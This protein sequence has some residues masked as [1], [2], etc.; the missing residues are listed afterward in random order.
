MTR[1]KPANNVTG[2]DGSNPL[3]IPDKAA[4]SFLGLYGSGSER[5]LGYT[6]IDVEKLVES[7]G[8]ELLFGTTMEEMKEKLLTLQKRR[9]LKAFLSLDENAGWLRKA[10]DL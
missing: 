8:A 5:K 3:G 9:H 7:V 4:E 10:K 6:K 1:A 2:S